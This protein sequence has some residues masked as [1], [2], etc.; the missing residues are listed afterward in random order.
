MTAKPPL[1]RL[2]VG[3]LQDA[4]RLGLVEDAA[5]HVTA[6]HQ[7]L[8]AR[9][10]SSHLS[11]DQLRHFQIAMQD[12]QVSL[13]LLHRPRRNPSFRERR[14]ATVMSFGRF[15]SCFEDEI[16]TPRS[17]VALRSHLSRPAS[18]KAAFEDSHRACLDFSARF[19]SGLLGAPGKRVRANAVGMAAGRCTWVASPSI[20]R[21][22]DQEAQYWRDRLGL[23]H[24]TAPPAPLMEHALVRVEFRITPT[25]QPLDR[26]DWKGS[27][28]K[29]PN[30]MWL[31]RPTILHKGNQRFVQSH[32]GDDAGRRRIPC[33]GMARDLGAPKHGL[34]EPEMLLICG[35]LAEM[36]FQSVTLLLGIAD[37]KAGRDNSDEYFVEHMAV[38]RRWA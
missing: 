37:E 31:I 8:A 13:D 36:R 26:R 17:S 9:W 7:R 16:A 21:A 3:N 2:I 30:G 20:K 19:G 38:E 35:V 11:T 33:H 29:N 22:G 6:L 1:L 14:I 32:E 27:T 12:T 5:G 23:I 18:D 34:G 10:S 25:R 24:V 15:A 4:V 28:A